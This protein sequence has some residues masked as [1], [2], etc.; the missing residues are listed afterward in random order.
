MKRKARLLTP[1][2]CCP[3]APQTR[4]AWRG[5]VQRA[6]AVQWG[7]APGLSVGLR[8]SG[9]ELWNDGGVLR[10][11]VLD[12]RCVLLCGGGGRAHAVCW[13]VGLHAIG[14]GVG[15]GV[16][17]RTRKL[18]NAGC[19][20]PEDGGAWT[21]KTIKRPPQ[22]PAHPQNA[23]YWAPLTRKWHITPH[24]AQPRHTNRCAPRTRKQH[25]QEHRPQ[26]PTERSDPMQHAKGRTGDCPGPRKGTATRW[27]VT[28]GGG[29]CRVALPPP[30]PQQPQPAQ[31]GGSRSPSTHTHPHPHPH[32][33]CPTLQA[34]YCTVHVIGSAPPP[35]PPNKGPHAVWTWP[36]GCFGRGRGG[37]RLRPD[38]W[39]GGPGVRWGGVQAGRPSQEGLPPGPP[40]PRSFHIPQIAVWIV[41][42]DVQP[43]V[44][45]RAYLRR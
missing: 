18:S 35:P 27:N 5:V 42:L 23:D 45:F 14:G 13:G 11:E 8:C 12:R 37:G 24:P 31:G 40:P 4:F 28:Q 7:S 39:P 44:R 30:P 32:T 41:L 26:R 36:T 17:S 16:A 20:W 19:G 10:R 33:R 29:D 9:A 38:S 21:A 22:Q 15:G 2:S 1:A 34:L 43:P 25:Q 3:S 6:A